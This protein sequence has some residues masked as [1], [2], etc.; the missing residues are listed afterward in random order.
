MLVTSAGEWGWRELSPEAEEHAAFLARLQ[1]ELRVLLQ[2]PAHPAG[3]LLA[4]ILTSS[5]AIILH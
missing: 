3:M 2:P 4:A 1:D 5:A